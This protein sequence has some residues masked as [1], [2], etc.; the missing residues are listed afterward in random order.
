MGLVYSEPAADIPSAKRREAQLKRWSRAKKEAL[1]RG[2]L[3]A[4]NQD[5]G[6]RMEIIREDGLRLGENAGFAIDQS[7]YSVE[8]A[9]A[10]NSRT[11]SSPSSFGNLFSFFTEESPFLLAHLASGNHANPLLASREDDEGRA[12]QAR[13]PQCVESKLRA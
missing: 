8:S 13:N 5:W 6:S 12:P 1:I 4:S 11:A 2:D 9:L 3:D 10:Q 7:R